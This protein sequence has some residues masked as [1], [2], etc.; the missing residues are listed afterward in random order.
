MVVAATERQRSIRIH[1]NHSTV[2]FRYLGQHIPVNNRMCMYTVYGIRY[3]VYG[4]GL[5]VSTKLTTTST[6]PYQTERTYFLISS[7]LYCESHNL[8]R[9]P[10]LSVISFKSSS[11]S[12]RALRSNCAPC[13]GLVRMLVNI[14]CVPMCSSAT[15]LS[16]TFSLSQRWRIF[17]Y[18]DLSDPGPPVA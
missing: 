4:I 12:I 1:N 14:S 13:T 18:R 3:T 15:S 10:R 11:W 5:T 7:K 16:V 9:T 8:Q 6:V 2:M 17:M